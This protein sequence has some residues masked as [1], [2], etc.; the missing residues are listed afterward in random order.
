MYMVKR[1]FKN[2]ELA[3]IRSLQPL[4]IRSHCIYLC[5]NSVFEL[6]HEFKNVG[7][8]VM[9]EAN[10]C[11]KKGGKDKK[12]ADIGPPLARTSL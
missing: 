10:L 4:G 3:T 11:L 6:W 8:R 9:A 2:S 1:I 7:Y 5:H 12:Q